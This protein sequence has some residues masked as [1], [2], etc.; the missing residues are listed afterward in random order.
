MEIVTPGAQSNDR[1]RNL[2]INH[3]IDNGNHQETVDPVMNHLGG[4]IQSLIGFPDFRTSQKNNINPLQ[5]LF[6][7]LHQSQLDQTMPM[8]Q[9]R[10]NQRKM[11]LSIPRSV[12]IGPLFQRSQHIEA[13]QQF[14]IR[15]RNPTT[16]I[17]LVSGNIPISNMF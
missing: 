3:L 15:S 11:S 12:S 10:M 13:S 1:R 16:A 5:N 2:G 8:L 14:E 4:M 6:M 9:R 7:S 17:V